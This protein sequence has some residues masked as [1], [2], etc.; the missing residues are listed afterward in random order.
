MAAAEAFLKDSPPCLIDAPT[1][2][3][4][5]A[6]R[7]AGSGVV[8]VKVSWVPG[9]GPTSGHTLDVSSVG[10]TLPSGSLAQVRDAVTL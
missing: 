7:D 8:T 3:V 2:L 5:A 1:V 4:A 6:S 9:V 10:T